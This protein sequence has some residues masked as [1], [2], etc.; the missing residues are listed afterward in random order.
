MFPTIL[1]T[2]FG[3]A[4]S[5]VILLLT[6]T[7][8]FFNVV[9]SSA[10]AQTPYY[11]S[12][13]FPEFS[14]NVAIPLGSFNVDNGNLNIQIPLY[15][16]NERGGKAESYRLV[17]NSTYWGTI[18]VPEQWIPYNNVGW[19]L[20][21]GTLGSQMN[22]DSATYICPSPNYTG[23]YTVY[24]NFR[25]TD[26]N[27]TTRVFQSQ[28][29]PGPTAGATRSSNCN[30]SDPALSPQPSTTAYATDGSG[31]VM[32]VT[33]YNQATVFSPS[34]DQVY[35]GKDTNGNALPNIPLPNLALYSALGNNTPN[36]P[37]PAPLVFYLDGGKYTI[38]YE[39]VDACTDFGGSG[40]ILAFCTGA[41]IPNAFY[42]SN[43]IMPSS[44]T[45]PDNRQYTFTYDSGASPGHYAGLTSIT[46]PT[47]GTE[48]FGYALFSADNGI[49]YKNRLTSVTAGTS[50]WT[51]AP[52]E[53]AGGLSVDVTGPA[54]NLGS[55]RDDTVYTTTVIT[56]YSGPASANLVL[57]TQTTTADSGRPSIV[58]TTVGGQTS[59][60]QYAYTTNLYPDAAYNNQ[61]KSIS[62]W[63]FGAIGSTP[64]REATYIYQP[65]VAY[66]N[67]HI[68]DRVQ[69]QSVYD[70]G[71]LISQ[72]TNSYD[73]TGLTATSGSDATS[74]AGLST[75]DDA[76]YGTGNT[77]RGNLTAVTEMVNATTSILTHTYY[78]NIL[79]D[80]VESTDGN[81]HSTYFDYTDSWNDASCATTPLF[82][83]PTT[84]TNALGYLRKT[85]YNS[86][87][88]TV[89]NTQDQNDINAGRTGTSY[90]HDQRQRVTSETFPDGG[91]TTI[92]YGG[93]AIPQVIS[94][95][96]V[97][98]P[99]PS[100][101]TATTLDGFGRVSQTTLASDPQ[102]ADIVV[103]TYDAVGNLVSVTNPH[104]SYSSP[105][106]DG[107]TTYKYDALGR[108]AIQVQPDNTS[109]LQWC[110]NGVVTDGQ[111]NCTAN[112]SALAAGTW[113]D[114][115]DESGKHWQRV[116]DA[117]GR[118]ISV[119]EP[120]AVTNV[121]SYETDYAYNALDNLI[122]VDQYGGAKGNATYTERVRT[123]TYDGLSRL[124]CASNPETSTTATFCPTSVGTAPTG[125]TTYGYDGDGNVTTRTDARTVVTGYVYDALNRVT[126]KTYD[127]SHAT[128]A[129]A[130][131]SNVGY[132][133]DIILQGWGWTPQTSPSWPNVSQT[134]LVGKLSSVSVGS[135]GA[136]AWTVYGYDQ[137]G[138]TILKS[139]CLP[140]DCGNNHH[141][142][143]YK[144][145]AAGNM[146]FY[147]RGLD[148][149]KNSTYPNQG[150][151][152]GGFSEQYDGAGNLS[153]VTGDTAGA[154]TTTNIWSNTDYFPTGQPYT[155]LALGLYN[156]K[157]SVTPRGWV[158]G[159]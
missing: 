155:V 116:S 78:Y 142:M 26:G 113:A 133:Y 139:E 119:M 152:Y 158:L 123:F 18:D 76:H 44:V 143:H 48:T 45:L 41:N 51:V 67:A 11:E 149:A 52:A 135:P 127:T 96:T 124:W 53:T 140:I 25:F 95:T 114:Y 66:A 83:Y 65:G 131:T 151:Y 93:T 129:I 54:R 64:T 147:D 38:R 106:T 46:L 21:A 153:A 34:G 87:D 14:R 145:D 68:L 33:S 47:G 79:G 73:T 4:K 58:T 72:T 118:L 40:G 59:K 55:V 91:S 128:V 3:S 137:M 61:I 134:N 88:G 19:T 159:R 69:I 63:D 98:T 110:Y 154:N 105:S 80:L 30:P 17:Y 32:I 120:D 132:L 136:N 148:I 99:N 60:R 62:E 28:A 43:L 71:G 89:A 115:S 22:N 35:P 150:Y 103:N 97:A 100:R 84:V 49:S 81:S 107:T 121:P 101:V 57:A 90:V 2:I 157:Y 50:V 15:T 8:V 122:R 37:V 102:G 138:R 92:S 23:T 24:S 42:Q 126:S 36:Q 94:T 112:K 27:G 86:C 1:R 104:R 144:Y 12:T 141:D 85:T 77:T 56:K 29:T 16:F 109:T 6:V 70:H 10:S 130:P 7:F 5:K 125:V 9:L 146:M 108:L 156:L 20:V 13:G 39:S 31:Y 74:V 111:T 117:F 75:H 82:A